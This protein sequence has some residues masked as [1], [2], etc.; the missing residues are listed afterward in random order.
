MTQIQSEKK[1]FQKL[2]FPFLSS[3]TIDNHLLSYN[4]AFKVYRRDLSLTAKDYIQGLIVCEKGQANMGRMEEEVDKGEYRRYQHFISNSKWGYQEL[5]AR[6]SLDV[7][8]VLGEYKKKGG[9]PTGYIIDEGAHLKKGTKPVGVSNQYAGVAGKV[10]NCQVAVYSSL[11][12]EN[13]ATIINEKLFLPKSWTSSKQ[14]CGE[15][16]IP[17]EERLYG[18]K[19]EPALKMINEDLDRGVKFDWM[20][21]GGLYGHSYL[22]TKGL[23]GIGK[24]YVLDVHKDE[25][26]F[27][28]KPTLYVAEKK[29][30]RGRE[31]KKLKTNG[32]PIRLDKYVGALKSIDW[33]GEKIR[34]TTKGRLKLQVHIVKIWVWNSKEGHVR[35]RTLVITKTKDKKTKIKYSF[36]NGLVD[37]YTKKEYAY[38]QTQRYWVERTFDDSKNGLGMSDYQIRK[39]TA[40]HH[41][42]SLVMLASVFLLKDKIENRQ[43]Y[44]LMSVRDARILVMVHMFGTKEQ[45]LMRVEQMKGR[46]RK[47]KKDIDLR[48]KRQE[49]HEENLK[50]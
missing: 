19:P 3:K 44:P 41:H 13:K 32:T 1:F 7:S 12:N 49:L 36:S 42:Q 4:S 31:P 48:Y 18:T 46:H 14:R 27:L 2:I 30:G 43:E 45:Y 28:E 29:Q 22:L 10:D 26:V 5:I 20:G 35:Q 40:W 39:W 24:L 47:R 50:S 6:I 38:F 34:K 25:L 33:S 8:N 17:E 11:V 37:E 15:A 21:G 16:K 23:D 9:M